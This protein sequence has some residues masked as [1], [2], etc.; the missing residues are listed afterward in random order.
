VTPEQE[1][2]ILGLV[3]SPGQHSH[4]PTTPE[5]LLAAFGAVDGRKLCRILLERAASESSANDVELT[6]VMS[7]ALGL[8]QTSLP[9]LQ[10]LAHESWHHSREDIA[11]LLKDLGGAELVDDLEFLAWAGPEF[12]PYEGSPSLARKVVHNLERIATPETLSRLRSHPESDVRALVDRI[13]Q[14][15]APQLG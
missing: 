6:L 8:D 9:V 12:Q 11:K 2:L 1:G 5:E 15:T 14:R 7:D 13:E 10:H 3:V 4:D